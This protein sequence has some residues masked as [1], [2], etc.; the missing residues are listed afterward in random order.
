MIFCRYGGISV[1]G[2]NSQVRMNETEIMKLISDLKI[3]LNISQ[4]SD[5]TVYFNTSYNPMG[6]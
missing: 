2:V 1:G 5:T 6:T 3:I 4:V